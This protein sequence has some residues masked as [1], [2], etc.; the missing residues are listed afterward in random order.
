[1]QKF[2]ACRNRGSSIHFFSSTAMR[3]I[4]A[5]WPAGPPKLTQPILSQVLKNSPKVGW[6][7]P[8]LRC[9]GEALSCTIVIAISRRLD[10]PVMA[11]F[12]REAQ[13]R[14]QRIVDHEAL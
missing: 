3:C 6:I 8:A 4:M 2:S 12:G 1:M 9:A 13:P 5:I 11:L 14:E 10:G 7:S